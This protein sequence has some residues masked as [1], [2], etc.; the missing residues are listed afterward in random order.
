MARRYLFTAIFL[1]CSLNLLSAFAY[2]GKVYLD[3]NRNGIFDAG[4]R[5]LDKV[6]V[7]DGLNVV[8]TDSN[9]SFELDGHVAARFIS[10]T[11]P[12]GFYPLSRHYIPLKGDAVTYDFAMVEYDA[13]IKR[14]GSH[15]FIQITDTEIYQVK[16]NEVW[17]HNVKEASVNKKAAFVVHTGDICYENGL[18]SHIDLMNSRNMGVPVY[19]CIGNHDM[20][21]GKYGEELFE[22]IY[23]PSWYSFEVGNTHYVVTPMLSGDYA[24][25]YSS[26]D[27]CRWLQND[28][29]CL[30]PGKSLVI[31]NHDLLTSGSSFVYK[32]NDGSQIDL[33]KYNLKAWIYGHIHTNLIRRQGDVL[34]ICSSSTDKGGIDHSLAGFRIFDVSSSGDILSEFRYQYVDNEVKIAAPTGLSGTCDLTVN[35]YSTVS[36]VVSVRYSCFCGDKRLCRNVPMSRKTD[37]TWTAEIPSERIAGKLVTVTADVMFDDGDI[38]S[39]T[40][41]FIYCP[42]IDLSLGGDWTN[43][44]GNASH[45]G[46]ATLSAMHEPRLVW[47]ANVGGNVFMASPVIYEDRIY[48]ATVSESLD[49]KTGVSALDALNG[50]ILWEYGTRGSVKNTIAVENGNVFAQDIYGFLYAIDAVTGKLEWESHLGVNAGL[51]PLLDGLAVAEGVVYAGS[52][53]GLSAYEAETGRLLWRNMDWNQG[54]GTTATLSI[55]DGAV[56]G[57]VQ[58]KALYCNDIDTGRMLWNCDSDGMRFRA[59][60]PAIYGHHV[61]VTS[62]KSF[63]ILD[64]SNGHVIARKDLPYNLEAT[65][66]PVLADGVIVFGTAD[67]GVIALDAVSLE[68]KWHFSTGDAIIYTAPYSRPGRKTVET[69]PLVSGECVFIGASDGCMYCIDLGTGMEIWKFYAGTPVFTTPAMSGNML[70]FAD[71]GGN[72]YAFSC[73]QD[74]Y[75]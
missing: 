21:R 67:S 73:C 22:S 47:T 74:G 35:A 24:P 17:A 23:G 43:L 53:K 56:V 51:P 36:D 27:V 48:T 8:M 40:S 34:T 44:L 14:D 26:A 29:A 72:V 28:L 52:G 7:S 1:G 69:S 59:S 57:S 75:R 55:G 9:G 50:D 71:Y 65:S 64:I 33:G 37:W 46:T 20:V 31:F 5:P 68:E 12:S 15:T 54:E 2:S 30:S 19:Y 39:D 3:K 38:T 60:T 13:G 10:V 63:F 18:R 49:G 70:V 61:Y 25:G 32:G 11:S 42:D 41:S 62:G 58:W 16:G 6:C 66:T 4:D 45:T